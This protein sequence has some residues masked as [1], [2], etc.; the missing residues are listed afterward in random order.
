VIPAEI[1]VRRALP[2]GYSL[3]SCA[4]S[5]R[6]RDRALPSYGWVTTLGR[7]FCCRAKRAA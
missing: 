7:P 2:R 6:S 5:L 4:G 3:V 1:P